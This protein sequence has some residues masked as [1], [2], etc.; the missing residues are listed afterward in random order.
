MTGLKHGVVFEMARLYS[1]CV[2]RH[3]RCDEGRAFGKGG[4]CNGGDG[5]QINGASQGFDDDV[6]L[7]PCVSLGSPLL[8]LAGV[9]TMEKRK[10]R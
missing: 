3:P 9:E 6:G 4:L 7:V 10:K 1:D 8:R 2:P 5:A